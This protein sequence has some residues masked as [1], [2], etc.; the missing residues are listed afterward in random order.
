MSKFYV[1]GVYEVGQ[2]AY[3][4]KLPDGTNQSFIE[5]DNKEEAIK[6][7][8]EYADTMKN[9]F[10]PEARLIRMLI[11]DA[12]SVVPEFIEVENETTKS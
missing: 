1:S 12:D 5:A 3:L 2:L 7:F 11:S 10:N 4:K 9:P 6:I 8:K